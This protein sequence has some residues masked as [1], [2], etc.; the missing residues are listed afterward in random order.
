M[1]VAAADIGTNSTRLLIADVGSDGSVAEGERL[2]EIT[3]LGE[4]VDASGSL[5]EA[6]MGRVTDTLERYAARARALSAERLLAVATSAVRDAANR[7]DFLVRVAASG[8]EPRL[9]TGDQEAATTFAGVCSRA[10]GGEPVAADGTLVVDVGGGSTELVLGGAGGVAWSRSLQ[11]GCVRMTERDLGE[12]VIKDSDLVACA[13]AIRVLLEVVPDAVVQA[14]RRA[15][16]VAGT[17]TTLA[18]IQHG[19]YDADAVHGARI[20]REDTRALEHR[21]AAMTLAERRSVPG[22]EA[23]RAPVIVA[24]LVVLG[25][26]LDRFGL[27]EAI[28]SERDILHGAALLAVGRD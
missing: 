16:A 28:V 11:A 17:A 14:T 18:A 25:S 24:G 4:G 1:R 5:A 10:P 13:T 27:A 2:L 8:F 7:D 20:T 22:L 3:R 21:L 23:A 12:D 26:V 15:I 9:L 6:P 19:G